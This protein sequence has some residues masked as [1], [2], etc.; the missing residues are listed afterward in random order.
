MLKFDHVALSI[1]D[2][3]ESIKFYEKLDF[4]LSQRWDDPNGNLSIILMKNSNMILEMFCYKNYKALPEY[5]HELSSDLE[6]IGTKHFGLC[7]ENINEA[8]KILC[9]KG[10]C[11]NPQIAKGRLGRDYF[12]IKD[13]NGILIEIIQEH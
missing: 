11:F 2:A 9:D 3:N 6:V 1:T 13:P 5:R 4:S 7:V 10:I 12:F 8:A